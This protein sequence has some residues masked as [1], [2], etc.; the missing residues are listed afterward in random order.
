VAGGTTHRDLL[1]PRLVH[2]DV[3]KLAMIPKG[4]GWKVHGRA[5]V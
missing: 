3:K 1:A 4:G 5:A 2:L